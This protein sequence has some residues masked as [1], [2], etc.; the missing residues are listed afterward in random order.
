MKVNCRVKAD[1]IIETLKYFQSE[2]PNEYRAGLST[3]GRTIASRMKKGMRSGKTPDGALAPLSPETITLRKIRQKK[4]LKKQGGRL[5]DGV[6]H[7]LY[8]RLGGLGV[9]VGFVSSATLADAVQAYQTAAAGQLNVYQRRYLH[10]MEGLLRGKGGKK[11]QSIITKWLERGTYEKPERLVV[12]PYS[13]MMKNEAVRIIGGTIKHILE[14][15]AKK[16][17]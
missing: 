4:G 11:S 15:K 7:Y 2:F 10:V 9:V 12:S 1:P 14:K 6:T 3:L 8:K 16:N 5:P 17:V 13:K